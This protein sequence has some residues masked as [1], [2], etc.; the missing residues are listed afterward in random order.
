MR[1]YNLWSLNEVG[2]VN[3]SPRCSCCYNCL[4]LGGSGQSF[5]SSKV[6]SLSRSKAKSLYCSDGGQANNSRVLNRLRGLGNILHRAIY[7]KTPLCDKP[8]TQILPTSPKMVQHHPAPPY[9][10]AAG[11]ASRTLRSTSILEPFLKLPRHNLYG[12]F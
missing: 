7:H 12:H 11:K 9:E 4:H 8:T 5:G 6:R 10:R 1:C 3:A 2:P